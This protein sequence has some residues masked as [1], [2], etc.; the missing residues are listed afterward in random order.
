MGMEEARVKS[1]ISDDPGE[2]NKKHV[3]GIGMHNVINRLKLFYN[4][5]AINDIIEIHSKVGSGTRVVLKIPLCE[6]VIEFD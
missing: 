3:S 5:S 1:I 4:I 6:D 2:T